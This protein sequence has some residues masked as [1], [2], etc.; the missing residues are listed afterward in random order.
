MRY[1]GGKSR[2]AKEIS[3]VVLAHTDNRAVY[4]EPFVGG[5][6]MAAK[7]A[8]HFEHVVLNDLHTDLTLMWDAVLNNG[9]EPPTDV[10]V[11]QYQELRY[12]EPSPARGFVGFGGSFG[13]KWFGGYAKGGFKANGEPRNYPDESARALLKDAEA[14]GKATVTNSSFENLPAVPARPVIY[15]DPPYADTTDYGLSDFPHELFWEKARQWA[16]SGADVFVSEYNAPEGWVPIWE[17]EVA[18]QLDL[19]KE[20]TKPVE[21]LFVWEGSN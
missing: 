10:T 18:G 6:A 13:G 8:P 5:G 9:W 15:C 12:S 16:E 1:M 7:L 19:R 21:K 17:K 11:E 3:E 20:R 4:V 14:I 2:I